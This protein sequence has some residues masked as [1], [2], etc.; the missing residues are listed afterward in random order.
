MPTKE[1]ISR[2]LG[3]GMNRLIPPKPSTKPVVTS[4]LVTLKPTEGRLLLG[5]LKG[6]ARLGIRKIVASVAPK[7]TIKQKM[8]KVT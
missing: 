3:W 5:L 4:S 1:I 2:L 8:P 6:E 7:A